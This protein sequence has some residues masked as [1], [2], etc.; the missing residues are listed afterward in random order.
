MT[1]DTTTLETQAGGYEP[2]HEVAMVAVQ[3]LCKRQGPLMRAEAEELVAMLRRQQDQD[4]G[5]A[6][7]S[8]TRVAGY[9]H[10]RLKA[11]AI[12]AQLLDVCFQLTPDLQAATE[13]LKERSW[14]A[15]QSRARATQRLTAGRVEAPKRA[16][17]V[18]QKPKV[19]VNDLRP[20]TKF[21]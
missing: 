8:L 16:P 20:K 19:S 4:L 21:S 18:G 7:T 11:P 14:D 10:T 5:D 15:A 1:V 17:R 12:A 2:L 3:W 13:R 9:F 6:L